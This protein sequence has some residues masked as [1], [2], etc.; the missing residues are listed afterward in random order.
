MTGDEA[1]EARGRPV[2]HLAHGIRRDGVARTSRHSTVALDGDEHGRKPTTRPMGGGDAGL[3]A[4][5]QGLRVESRSRP[6]PASNVLC[7]GIFLMGLCGDRRFDT[8][9][10]RTGSG[11]NHDAGLGPRDGGPSLSKRS[12]CRATAHRGREVPNG[13]RP[14]RLTCSDRYQSRA[15]RRAGR[16]WGRFGAGVC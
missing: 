2:D 8:R 3:R 1:V 12:S 6:G 13:F 16:L 4:H 7:G 14:G 5:N 15:R 10:P 9:S 11:T